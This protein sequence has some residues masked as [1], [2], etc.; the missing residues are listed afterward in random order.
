VII[1]Y[2]K[3]EEIEQST[4]LVLGRR[5]MESLKLHSTFD[6]RSQPSLADG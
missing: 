5:S 3:R 1:V 4:L 6:D 2:R